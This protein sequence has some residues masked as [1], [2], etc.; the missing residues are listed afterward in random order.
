MPIL[1]KDWSHSGVARLYN[2]VIKNGYKIVYLSSR[3]IGQAGTTRNYLTNLRQDGV[4]LPPGPVLMSPFRLLTAFKKE[5]IDRRPEVFKIAC[6]QDIKSICPPSASPF[7][8][9]FGNRV[10]DLISYESVGIPPARIFIIN[11][12]GQIRTTN[13]TFTQS[14]SS[15]NDIVEMVFPPNLPVDPSYD[16]FTFWKLPL[17]PID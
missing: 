17:P 3:A 8:A 4:M 15:L 6:L 1:G 14:Y 2:S 12:A 9:G 7:Y 10:T 5:V 11:P 13:K 16:A